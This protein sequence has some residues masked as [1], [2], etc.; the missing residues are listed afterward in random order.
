MK[1]TDSNR[2]LLA[3]ILIVLFMFIL[4]INAYMLFTEI[5]K[6]TLYNSRSYG[7]STLNDDFDQGR[8]FE[9]YLKTA[10][11]KYADDELSVDVSQYAAFGRYYY[12][13]IK[14]ETVEDNAV[15]LKQ[16]EEAKAEISWKKILNVIRILENDM[17]TRK[18]Q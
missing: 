7:L 8:Y 18:A 2:W 14:A 6:D 9:V 4:F 15:Y 16:M 11:N 12:A 13:Y 17:E 10:R 3:R 1:K 5:R